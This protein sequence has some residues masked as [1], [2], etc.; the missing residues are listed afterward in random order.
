MQI[1]TEYMA[2]N[3]SRIILPF[4]STSIWDEVNSLVGKPNPH[5]LRGQM[6][7]LKTLQ[8]E[9]LWLHFEFFHLTVIFISIYIENT[10]NFL[11]VNYWWGTVKYYF[12]N[13]LINALRQI[14]SVF[15]LYCHN[16]F[17][18]LNL[19]GNQ[20]EKLISSVIK[21]DYVRELCSVNYQH[22]F[23]FISS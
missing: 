1:Y 10:P 16:W 13:Y 17:L 23:A 3:Y 21:E 20:G 12:M 2:I 14:Y 19:L 8:K 4:E 5:T 6:S 22:S 11:K 18:F 7:Q 15:G 9:A